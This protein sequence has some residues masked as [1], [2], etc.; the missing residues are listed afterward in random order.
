MQY[1]NL[2]N[3]MNCDDKVDH[4]LFN[5]PQLLSVCYSLYDDTTSCQDVFD[6]LQISME[7]TE[8]KQILVRGVLQQCNKTKKF[9]IVH[10]INRLLFAQP[11]A[12][13]IKSN[14][15]EPTTNH[16]V[17]PHPPPMSTC[18]AQYVFQIADLV[19]AIYEYL[20]I[21]SLVECR[22]LSRQFAYD[23]YKFYEKMRV[24]S[25]QKLVFKLS[26][27]GNNDFILHC[28]WKKDLIPTANHLTID[29][30]TGPVLNNIVEEIVQ[31]WLNSD[32]AEHYIHS[33]TFNFTHELAL[34]RHCYTTYHLCQQMQSPL[35]SLC[36]NFP[37]KL[38][39]NS[40]ASHT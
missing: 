13:I 18:S 9:G 16:I 27:C 24:S 26:N 17:R 31:K 11:N 6:T 30:F 4:E 39:G 7:P 25:W 29:S 2:A 23:F 35:A 40:K 1:L 22:V 21:D 8:L 37:G 20:D 38:D 12:L 36:F 33:A 5:G 32:E 34:W 19:T 28:L 15:S 10:S 3:N 14:T